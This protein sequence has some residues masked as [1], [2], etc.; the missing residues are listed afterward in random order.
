MIGR[1][2]WFAVSALLVG[3]GVAQA[4]GFGGPGFGRGFGGGAG[5]V[6]TGEPFTDASTSTSVDKL[7]D[8]TT[9]THKSTCTEARDAEGRTV[10]AITTTNGTGA[11]STRTTLFDPVA[12]TL[13]N[14][15]TTSTI[16]TQIQLPTP[17]P[18]GRGDWG[19]PG[20]PG[21]GGPGAAGRV[22]PQATRVVLSPTTI[23]GV[24]ATGVKTTITVPEGA[25]GNDKPL[26]ST[27]EVWTSST[28][29][30]VLEE[31]SDSPREGFHK[32]EVTSL[33]QG[34]PDASLFQVPSNYT[35][36]VETR[37]RGGQ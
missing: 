34:A 31:I 13:T 10:T 11:P 1:R 32:M 6:V 12:H 29:K 22:R 17:P 26:V 14:W 30:I 35:V 28:L 15:S 33:T 37:H 8:G 25:E 21:P 27:R 3:S 5:H 23:A 2:G 16:A 24:S 9:I 18:G 20:G 7:A 4:Q 19:G 36:K